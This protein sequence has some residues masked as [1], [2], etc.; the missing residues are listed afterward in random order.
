MRPIYLVDPGHG[1]RDSGAVSKDGKTA[2]KDI[3][4][5]VGLKLFNLLDQD[6]RIEA[7][8]TRTDDS[9]LTLSERVVM[10]N[11]LNANIVSVHANA[12]GGRGYEVF[13]YHGQ[14]ESD[15]LATNIIDKY[16]QNCPEFPLR[17]DPS[18]G[19]PDK[20]ASFTVLTNRKLSVLIE[21]G[22][23]D[24]DDI[25]ILR[26]ENFKHRA[27]KGI[28]EGIVQYEFGGVAAIDLSDVIVKEIKTAKARMLALAESI[29]R[30][31]QLSNSL[32]HQ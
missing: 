27:A 23:M 8:I 25:N 31:E 26:S 5:S 15:K 10:A 28:Y 21:L 2:E 3:N 13:T 32:T 16:G 1:D 11:S 12:G 17:A 4:L 7:H 30:L 24:S 19:D 6:Q 18:D 22:F 29:D 20:E 9:F 14:T